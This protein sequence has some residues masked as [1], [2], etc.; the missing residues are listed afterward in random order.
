MSR[1]ILYGYRI[2]VQ[3]VK[4]PT[5]FL[6]RKRKGTASEIKSQSQSVYIHVTDNTSSHLCMN[7]SS[8][9]IRKSFNRL[10]SLTSRITLSA[11]E[12]FR[13]ALFI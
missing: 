3:G 2:T 6:P 8:R 7:L 10:I 1:T 9:D 11:R 5:H 4:F 13:R 12:A